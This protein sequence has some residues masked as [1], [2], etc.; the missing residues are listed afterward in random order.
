MVSDGILEFEQ[1]IKERGQTAEVGRAVGRSPSDTSRTESINVTDQERE[2]EPTGNKK[3]ITVE[4]AS[5]VLQDRP[6]S[7][8]GEENNDGLS[9]RPSQPKELQNEPTPGDNAEQPFSVTGRGGDSSTS[10][11]LRCVKDGIVFR[12]CYI[13]LA[14]RATPRWYSKL[15]KTDLQDPR[16]LTNPMLAANNVASVR[17]NISHQTMQLARLAMFA[18]AEHEELRQTPLII[19]E[20]PGDEAP[21]RVTFH[22][23]FVQLKVRTNTRYHESVYF[24]AVLWLGVLSSNILYGCLQIPAWNAPLSTATEI[25]FWRISIVM[26]F[27]PVAVVPASLCLL[28]AIFVAVVALML[29]GFILALIGA[30][31]YRLIMLV[32]QCW[33]L[34]ASCTGRSQD[35]GSHELL[36]RGRVTADRTEP[37]TGSTGEVERDDHPVDRRL[38]GW[39]T[40]WVSLI[41]YFLMAVFCLSRLYILVE[42]FVSLAYAPPA[43]F[44]LP[45]L[46]SYFP[47]I[48]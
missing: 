45:N 14:S 42:C 11:L 24:G 44:D 10:L 33:R 6:D 30:A 8:A 15:K 29:A 36:E 27:F 39:L 25:L 37:E 41:F 13:E 35:H 17:M 34:I 31:I 16:I 40:P 22:D 12:A 2:N 28:I 43:V 19:P 5:V 46:A 47:H 18:L 32:R 3:S 9:P 48:G 26:M 23:D 4:S 38:V 7:S 21:K 20:E 1:D